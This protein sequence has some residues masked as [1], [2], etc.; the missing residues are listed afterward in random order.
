MGTED[1]FFCDRTNIER[2]TAIY[3]NTL[4]YG[5]LLGIWFPT[6]S[7]CNCATGLLPSLGYLRWIDAAHLSYH[8]IFMA[9]ATL[10]S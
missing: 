6:N 3:P 8:A 7:G 1:Y 9:V 2:T 10:Q 5:V 4:A